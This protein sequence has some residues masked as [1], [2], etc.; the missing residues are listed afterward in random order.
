MG[1]YDVFIIDKERD[2]E[3]KAFQNNDLRVFQIGDRI[4]EAI[5]EKANCLIVAFEDVIIEIKDGIFAGFKEYKALKFVSPNLSG[6]GYHFDA[7]KLKKL[8]IEK[9]GSEYRNI[10]VFD[11]YGTM[12]F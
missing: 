1:L 5:R 6:Y 11:K 12:L 10:P 8:I 7:E 2:A 4:P 9:Y 3:I